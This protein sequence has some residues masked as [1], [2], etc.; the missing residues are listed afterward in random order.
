MLFIITLIIFGFWAW[1]RRKRDSKEPPM[2]PG[3][4]PLIGHAYHFIGDSAEVVLWKKL[5]DVSDKCSDAG[6]VIQAQIG[7]RTVYVVTDPED[8]MTISNACLQ[9]DGYYD[10]AKPWLG[11]GLVTGTLSIW[12]VHRKLLNPAFS[13][14]VLDGFLDLLNRQARRLVKDLSAE[15]GKGPFDH[16]VYTRHNAIE[17]ICLTALGVDFSDKT[18]LTAEYV[19]ATEKILNVFVERFL[20]I[21]WH[22][23][24]LYDFSNLKKKQD[25]LLKILHHMSITVL[26]KRKAEYLKNRNNV[27]ETEKPTITGVK[28]KPF[29]DLLLELS[30]EKGAF[31]DREIREHIDTMI[32]GGH[33]TSAAVLM[34]SLLLIG[35][36]PEVQE[37]IFDELR[38]VFGDDDR[39]AS[40]H[41]LSQ[42]VYLEA[43]LKESMRIYPIVP[44]IARALDKDVKLR[45]CTLSAGR[46]CFMLVCGI[47]RYPCWGPDSA[48]FKPERWLDQA[49]LPEHPGAFAAFSMGRRICIGKSYAYMS[50]KTTLAHVLRHYK[51][52]GDHSKLT[53]K[54]DVM[55]KP[56]GGHHISIERRKKLVK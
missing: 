6:G 8:C 17:T 30:I 16:W 46:T 19:Q 28:F 42:L 2:L 37:K 10:F 7:P 36:Y 27:E 32:I 48:Q 12:R 1:N 39:D 33:D 41:D 47:H 53:L 35:S 4:V 56:V 18:I 9:K 31:D 55:L 20:K 24:F 54:M 49:N 50:M 3:A 40:K 34:F 21:W 38:E 25:E 14:I 51:V 43:V 26:K 13:Q 23:N 29:M 44:V 11:E 15:V 45:H 52:K 22:N 5:E